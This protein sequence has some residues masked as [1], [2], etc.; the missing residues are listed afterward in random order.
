MLDLQPPTPKGGAMKLGLIFLVVSLPAFAQNIVSD[1]ASA[2][3]K[4]LHHADFVSQYVLQGSLSVQ[5]CTPVKAGD[6]KWLL[7]NVVANTRSGLETYVALYE[8]KG[9][10]EKAAPVFKSAALG[11]DSYPLLVKNVQRLLFVHPATDKSRIVFYMSTQ[12]GPAAARLA[13]WEY[14]VDKKELVETN[15]AWNFEA[16]VMAKIYQDKQTWRSL[17]DIRSVEL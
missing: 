13:R 3:V 11:F 15:R 5:D 8:R 1:C 2:E 16:G 17:I 14:L 4:I 7:I 6:R 12:T 10:S 9:F